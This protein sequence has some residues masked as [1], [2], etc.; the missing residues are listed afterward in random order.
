ML[1][2]PD[3]K[4]V[5]SEAAHGTVTRH[6]REH[7]AGKETSTNPL[8]TLFAWT[9]ALYY[10]GLFDKT[11]EVQNFATALEKACFEAVESGHM[12]KDLALLTRQSSWLT[13]KAFLQKIKLSLEERLFT[14]MK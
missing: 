11:P 6:F 4:I 1:L 7:Q 2:T 12:T 14:E 10:R 9:R 5:L 8:A 3:G 13:T